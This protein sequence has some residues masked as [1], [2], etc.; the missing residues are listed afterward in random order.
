MERA[1]L[2]G[3]LVLAGAL[4]ST[5]TTSTSFSLLIIVA[6]LRRIRSLDRWFEVAARIIRSKHSNRLGPPAVGDRGE[7]P[8]LKGPLAPGHHG[9]SGRRRRRSGT[10]ALV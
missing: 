2:T 6:S 9:A 5:D 8:D 1:H 3:S 10:S 4:S 7:R